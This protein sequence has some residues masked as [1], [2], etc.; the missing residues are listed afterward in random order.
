MAWLH[1][2]RNYG[3]CPTHN[4]F[5]IFT[6]HAYYIRA[7]SIKIVLSLRSPLSTSPST[8]HWDHS[9]HVTEVTLSRSLSPRHWGPPLHV[10]EVPP[11]HVTDAIQGKCKTPYY[12]LA[13][14]LSH[15]LPERRWSQ[16]RTALE[17]PA[18]DF[19]SEFTPEAFPE[20]GYGRQA[21]EVWNQD[22]PSPRW[23]T[24]QSYQAPSARQFDQ[25]HG[26]GC[27]ALALI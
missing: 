8:H 13:P 19:S 1:V 10:T 6:K 14:V 24:K 25:I 20:I 16:R 3:L 26:N 11:L 9:L 4:Y 7:K 23:A 15:E 12:S 2:W 27:S 5:L 21:A 22:F 17:T 18:P